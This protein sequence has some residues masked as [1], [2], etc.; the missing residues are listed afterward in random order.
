MIPEEGVRMPVGFDIGTARSRVASVGAQGAVLLPLPGGGTELDSVVTFDGAQVLVGRVPPGCGGDRDVVCAPKTRLGGPPV[1]LSGGAIEPARIVAHL[2]S[3]LVQ[4]A[5]AHLQQRP[6]SAVLT[7]PAWFDAERIVGLE[8]AAAAAGLGV[9]R[10]ILDLTGVALHAL[11]R[12]PG[13][14]RLAVVDAGAGGLGVGI[15]RVADRRLVLEGVA[16]EW[17]HSD[18]PQRLLEAVEGS[19]WFALERAGRGALDALVLAGG[20]ARTPGLRAV[21]ESS[22]GQR[23]S[24]GFAP[25]GAV[26]LGAA[27]LAYCLT[28]GAR[29]VAVDESTH[30]PALAAG[31]SLPPDPPAVG[32]AASAPAP[33]ATRAERPA[34]PARPPS[35]A[36]AAWL[37]AAI[38][39]GTA[40]NPRTVGELIALPLDRPLTPADLEHLWLPVLLCRVL[41]RRGVSGTMTLQAGTGTA[42]LAVIGGQPHLRAGER[43]ALP[44]AFL[45]DRVDYAFDPG[46][47]D[48]QGRTVTSMAKLAVEGLRARGRTFSVAELERGI[49]ARLEL[50]PVVRAERRGL[51]GKL[52]L[53]RREQRL[54]DEM[55]GFHTAHDLG[56]S[57]LGPHTTLQ[58]CVVLTA[59]GFVDWRPVER[60]AE[61]SLHQQLEQRAQRMDAA[62]H[63]DA[64][65]VHWSASLT[66]AEQAFA[67]LRRELGPGTHEHAENPEACRRMLAR[68]ER[69]VDALRDPT[70]LREY[71]RSLHPDI[72]FEALDDL[73]AKRIVALQMKHEEREVDESRRAREVIAAVSLRPLRPSLPNP[74]RSR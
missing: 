51:V 35:R 61:T 19:A 59:F 67:S 63:F 56:A 43:A 36:T 62:N 8:Q 32:G 40:Y 60:R 73:M 65:G 71:R 66:D 38:G 64:L 34:A 2:I 28:R 29:G 9:E 44:R 17:V 14:R 57:G 18:D 16:G 70:A 42:T 23:S 11:A 25:P 30:E 50:A 7:V 21:V 3:F 26:A 10:R 74:G 55:D 24:E 13:L 37:P 6:A 45:W 39:A 41:A 69:A 54:V 22:F 15:Y 33:V 1:E 72:D 52:G 68:A 46:P 31:R 47:P 12:S 53:D 5:T 48:E 27:I 49:G 4:V 20:R 58:L